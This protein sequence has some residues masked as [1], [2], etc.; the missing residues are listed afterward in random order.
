MKD[1]LG[2]T[3]PTVRD[4]KTKNYLNIQVIYLEKNR[5]STM[6]PKLFIE[7]RVFWRGGENPITKQPHIQDDRWLLCIFSFSVFFLTEA[8]GTFQISLYDWKK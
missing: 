1:R 5:V 7:H 8:N 3:K 6:I 4:Y 2:Q